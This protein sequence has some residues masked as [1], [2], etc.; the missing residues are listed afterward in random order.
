MPDSPH[1]R[2]NIEIG[3]NPGIVFTSFTNIIA[4]TASIGTKEKIVMLNGGGTA[5]TLAHAVA[6]PLED[7]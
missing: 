6:T 3:V 7:A 4:A 2:G 1:I 5:P